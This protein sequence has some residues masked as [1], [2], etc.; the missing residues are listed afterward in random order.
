MA[1]TKMGVV[2]LS[3]KKRVLRHIYL[4]DPNHD[5]HPAN[6]HWRREPNQEAYARRDDSELLHPRWLDPGEEMVLIDLAHHHNGY[7]TFHQAIDDAI[8]A[9]HGVHPVQFPD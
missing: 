6:V 8:F 3:D 9:K 5:P 7:A 1:L 2:Y 4:E